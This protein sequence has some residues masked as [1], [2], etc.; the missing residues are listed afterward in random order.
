MLDKDLFEKEIS[1]ERWHE[2]DDA[3]KRSVGKKFY[4]EQDMIVIAL[5]T[6]LIVCLYRCEV[7]LGKEA[8]LN[9]S[10][11]EQTLT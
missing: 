3:K 11:I 2:A 8:S 9:K 5:H 6:D 7:K 10:H 4:S 1:R